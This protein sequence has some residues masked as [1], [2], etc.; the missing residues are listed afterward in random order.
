MFLSQRPTLHRGVRLGFHAGRTLHVCRVGLQLGRGHCPHAGGRGSRSGWLGAWPDGFAISKDP[1]HPSPSSACRGSRPTRFKDA[2]A[3]RGASQNGLLLAREGDRDLGGRG[4][5]VRGAPAQGTTPKL[6]VR[7]IMSSCLQYATSPQIYL[8]LY[9]AL[10][11]V[12]AACTGRGQGSCCILEGLLLHRP[13][14]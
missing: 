2:G 5:R 1:R 14:G 3:A 8:Y 12:F 9:P 4:H 6:C 13:Y 7:N 10:C 11:W